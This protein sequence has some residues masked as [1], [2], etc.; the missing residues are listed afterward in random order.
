MKIWLVIIILF[1]SNISYAQDYPINQYIKDL[2]TD[3]QEQSFRLNNAYTEFRKYDNNT[4]IKLMGI[5]ENSVRQEKS[6]FLQVRFSFFKMFVLRFFMDETHMQAIKAEF[7][8]SIVMAKELKNEML[9]ADGYYWYALFLNDHQQV[10]ESLFYN[11]KSIEL[12][13]KLGLENFYGADIRYQLLGQLLYHT[14]EYQKSIG[15][16]KKALRYNFNNSVN[17]QQV[18]TLNTI[19]L[20][21]QKLHQADSAISYFDKS[22]KLADS[23]N[24]EIWVTIPNANKAQ[25]WFAQKKYKQ[26]FPLFEADYNASVKVGDYPN[27]ANNLQWMAKIYLAAGK[28]E[29]ALKKARQALQILQPYPKK[30]NAVTNTYQTLSAIYK[31]Q[32]KHDSSDHYSLLYNNIHDSTEAVVATSNSEIIQLRVDDER[33]K[34]KI[35]LLQ[36]DQQTEKMNRNVFIG[37]VLLLSLII[38]FLY[39]RQYVKQKEQEQ[40]KETELKVANEQMQLFTKTISENLQLIDNLQQQIEQQNLDPAV[41][42]NLEMLKQKTILTEEDWEVFQNIFEKIYTGFFERLRKINP[43]ITSAELRFASIIRLQM[44]NKQAGAMLGISPDSAR[45]T[46]LRLRQRL[47]I[48]EESNVE[49]VIQSL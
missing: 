8:Q 30:G 3:D 6:E 46:R 16:S 18:S 9:L 7:R 10:A 5:I 35:E 37:F 19:G 2:A 21:Y 24:S 28:T 14:R 12:V 33:N 1:F 22:A 32:N 47:N 13:E 34:S 40:L 15:F 26:A 20:A 48:T 41:K 29:S 23:Q 17:V 39:K 43:S 36:K 11:L 49:Q 27:A 42:Q 4:Q 31:Q 25:I 38:F 45:K 44:N